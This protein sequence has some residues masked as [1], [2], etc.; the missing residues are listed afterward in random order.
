MMK[1][2][3]RKGD[4]VFIPSDVRLIQFQ[5]ENATHATLPLFI[6]KHIT[7]NKP[8]RVLLMDSVDKYCKIYYDGEYWFADKSDVYEGS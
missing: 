3:F 1:N 8:N 4:L 2:K 7:T 5:E 6:N